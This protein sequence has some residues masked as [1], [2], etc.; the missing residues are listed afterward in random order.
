MI[1]I[2]KINIYYYFEHQLAKAKVTLSNEKI[3]ETYTSFKISD[4]DVYVKD[5]QV[6][7]IN[8]I[9]FYYNILS[10]IEIE[11]NFI[12]ANTLINGKIDLL[13]KRIIFNNIHQTDE[14]GTFL[15]NLGFIYINGFYEYE[16]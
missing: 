14:M 3:Q 1:F 11:L 7:L 4:I 12:V 13:S 16:Y 10:P 9:Q 15:S 8:E 6:L 5:K 2:P